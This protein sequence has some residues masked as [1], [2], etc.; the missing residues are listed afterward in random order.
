MNFLSVHLLLLLLPKNYP[1]FSGLLTGRATVAEYG[2]FLAFSRC[3][4]IANNM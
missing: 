3:N 4:W 2:E 1:L